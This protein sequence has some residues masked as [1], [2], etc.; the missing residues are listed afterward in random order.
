MDLVH[1]RGAVVF[2][3]VMMVDG[4]VARGR[5]VCLNLVSVGRWCG[6]ILVLQR[7]QILNVNVGVGVGRRGVDA[8]GFDGDR[9]IRDHA[10]SVVRHLQR[11][12]DALRLLG[13]HFIP[14]LVLLLGRWCGDILVL[15]RLTHKLQILNVGVGVGRGIDADGFEGD[16]RIHSVIRHLQREGDALRLLGVQFIPLLLLL[17]RWC[18]AAGIMTMMMMIM[19]IS[20]G[21]RCHVYRL[22]V[23]V[24]HL[25]ARRLRLDGF[26]VRRL[27]GPAFVVRVRRR[28]FS[29]LS[30]PL[31]FFF[32]PERDCDRDCGCHREYERRQDASPAPRLRRVRRARSEVADAAVR[33]P[34]RPQARLR[35][36]GPKPAL[37]GGASGGCAASGRTRPMDRRHRHRP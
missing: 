30:G 5:V 2:L 25:H 7:L 9:R 15:Q 36:A 35:S 21:R 3:L 10:N 14:L 6:D 31:P 13:V 4:V 28:P 37:G 8:D 32:L 19:M 20:G 26:D 33:H 16:R 1:D 34:S 29:V 17:G 22:G 18:N 27:V 24:F 12:G 11:E 23:R